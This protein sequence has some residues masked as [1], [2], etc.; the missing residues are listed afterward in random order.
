MRI[1]DLTPFTYGTPV[2]EGELCIGWLDGEQID[3]TGLIQP[4]RVRRLFIDR[5]IF[6]AA[7]LQS[8]HEYWMG[9]HQCSF[10]DGPTTPLR[11]DFGALWGNGEFRVRSATGTVFVA[12]TLVAH[13]VDAH[14]YRPPEEF[15]NAVLQGDFIEQG[16]EF[17]PR[18]SVITTTAAPSELC[19]ALGKSIDVVTL[20]RHP[21]DD[22]APRPML[23]L[24]ID[25][26]V[27]APWDGS[28]SHARRLLNEEPISV[29][30]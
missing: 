15:I 14:G 6:A 11:T 26:Q 4:K 16:R 22:E 21:S 3:S 27:H 30:R 5:L 7:Y 20:N 19:D 28:L 18:F 24:Q 10:C 23:G 25:R 29:L 17:P 1:A 12:P 2:V 8:G 13:Y 9:I